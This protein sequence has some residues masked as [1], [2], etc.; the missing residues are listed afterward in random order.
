MKSIKI[1]KEQGIQGWCMRALEFIL[2]KSGKW[3]MDIFK[4]F[5]NMMITSYIAKIKVK[6]LKHIID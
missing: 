5:D 3:Q 4:A 6:I 2:K 1:N